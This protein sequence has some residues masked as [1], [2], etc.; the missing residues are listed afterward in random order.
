MHP[1]TPPPAKYSQTRALYFYFCFFFKVMSD[2]MPQTFQQL[3]TSLRLKDFSVYKALPLDPPSLPPPWPSYCFSPCFLRG[4]LSSTA[5]CPCCSSTPAGKLPPGSLYSSCALN[6]ESSFSRDPL[7]SSPHFL[8]IFAQISLLK[9]PTLTT[10]FNT[11]HN[12]RPAW[13]LRVP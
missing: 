12:S 13:H 6:L 3:H 11:A 7:G 1:C 9:K 2:P 10:I 5:L 8:P 4:I